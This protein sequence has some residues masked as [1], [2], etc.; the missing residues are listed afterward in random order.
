MT[1]P[2]QHIAGALGAFRNNRARVLALSAALFS[3]IFWLVVQ[4]AFGGDESI[5]LEEAQIFGK[6]PAT[7]D[8]TRATPPERPALST[9][10]PWEGEAQTV[11]NI[12]EEILNDLTQPDPSYL[13]E[14]DVESQE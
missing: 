12:P 13:S 6:S 5:V 3:V 7:E 9:A 11:F 8:Q 1:H 10:F 14:E 2:P 4:G